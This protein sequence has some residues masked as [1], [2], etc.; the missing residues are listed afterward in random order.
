MPLSRLRLII[1]LW[2]IWA[3]AVL[4]CGGFIK[5]RGQTVETFVSF[6]L[7]EVWK[8]PWG[9]QLCGENWILSKCESCCI[10]GAVELWGLC[11][12]KESV[13]CPSVHIVK[14]PEGP[15]VLQ[16]SSDVTPSCSEGFADS[17]AATLYGNINFHVF[18]KTQ[19]RQMFLIPQSDVSL[20]KTGVC[21]RQG[22][23]N[24]FDFSKSK[25]I[26][27]L[28]QFAHL[29]L[30]WIWFPHLWV[31]NEHQWLFPPC[32]CLGREEHRAGTCHTAN[33]VEV[34]DWSVLPDAVVIILQV[35]DRQSLSRAMQRPE[36]DP[37]SLGLWPDWVSVEIDPACALVSVSGK[38]CRL[39]CQ[40][41]FPPPLILTPLNLFFSASSFFSP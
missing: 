16:L 9:N 37:Y 20:F 15:I 38:V 18:N 4:L 5:W 41:I 2:D 29:V 11:A 28:L 10:P 32:R 25:Q 12:A 6:E 8:L 30:F 34:M 35:P 27:L 19:D 33:G 26:R 1:W 3:S 13:S 23:I 14:E 31:I 21:N 40:F 7:T 17:W 39:F 24:Q 22:L 36:R